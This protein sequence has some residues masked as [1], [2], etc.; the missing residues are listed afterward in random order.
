[1]LLSLQH[2]VWCSTPAG[3]DCLN[4]AFLSLQQQQ[5]QPLQSQQQP[6]S[7]LE[8]ANGSADS[9]VD[10]STWS[11]TDA[12][13]QAAPGKPESTSNSMVP[14]P[15][16]GRVLLFFSVNSSGCFCGVAEMISSVNKMKQLP[17]WQDSRWRG[18]FSVRWLYAKNVPNRLLRHILVE[19]LDNR[20][21]T[22]LRDTNEIV[23]SSKGEEMLRIIHKFGLC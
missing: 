18:A 7:S 11:G 2:G 10:G 13:S 8:I 12:G 4:K 1:V 20:A 15:P 19:S 14:A 22:H 16:V 6:A 21:V 3:N 17:I 5:Q 23:P 9:G